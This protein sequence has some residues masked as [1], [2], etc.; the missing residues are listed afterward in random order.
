[1]N[2]RISA[3]VSLIRTESIHVK[4]LTSISM[5][6]VVAMRW[7]RVI[8][9]REH[10][11]RGILI[12]LGNMRENSEWGN[13]IVII[14]NLLKEL[15][16]G[17]FKYLLQRIFYHPVRPSCKRPIVPLIP[18]NG[19]KRCRFPLQ[20]SDDHCRN[21]IIFFRSRHSFVSL[22]CRVFPL[23]PAPKAFNW[24]LPRRAFRA[25]LSHIM[26][27]HMMGRYNLR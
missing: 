13:M 2:L 22:P 24:H 15:A 18:E 3:G 16:K 19:G 5:T 8:I 1:M 12:S 4:Y 10:S 17:N 20:H 14:R 23:F 6:M 11:K 9:G 21:W 7:I 27:S 26:Q 25:R